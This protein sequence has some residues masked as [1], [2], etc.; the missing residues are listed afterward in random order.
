MV[1]FH[2]E[3]DQYLQELSFYEQLFRT[4]VSYRFILGCTSITDQCS[5]FMFVYVCLCLFMFV[6]VCLCLLMF[7]DVCLC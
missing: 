3:Y 5:L 7:V 2:Y 1:Y 6:Y 4:I